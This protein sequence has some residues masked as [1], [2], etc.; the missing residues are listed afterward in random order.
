MRNV[1]LLILILLVVP[2]SVHAQDHPK[3]ELFGGYSFAYESDIDSLHGFNAVL[4][5][6]FTD[7]FGIVIDNSAHFAGIFNVSSP[8]VNI[9]SLLFGPQFS[10]RSNDTVTP[11]VR[12]LIGLSRLK[13]GLLGF[14]ESTTAF[15]IGGGGGL[16]INVAEN[17][18]IR[19]FQADYIHARAE[20]GSTNI[21]R[22]SL[23]VVGKW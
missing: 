22:L 21:F 3:I 2:A 5:V 7:S 10:V 6:N 1:C 14:S 16:D 13:V 17:L 8:N 19:A 9:Y 15:S 20:G 23:G 12:A 11:F 18:A 4:N